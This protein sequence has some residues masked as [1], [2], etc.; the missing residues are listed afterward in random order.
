MLVTS[1]ERAADR[2]RLALHSEINSGCVH[3]RLRS[4][5]YEYEIKKRAEQLFVQNV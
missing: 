5:A 1:F 3:P 4:L 2:A